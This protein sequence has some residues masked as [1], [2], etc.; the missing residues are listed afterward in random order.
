MHIL[1]DKGLMT[2]RG[3]AISGSK[4]AR[5]LKV[6][7]NPVREDYIGD[8][9][10]ENLA[11]NSEVKITDVNG[12]IVYQTR[13]NGGMAIWNGRDENNEK[14]ATGVYLIFAAN[15]NKKGKALGKILII[16]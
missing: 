4:E 11:Y 15:N 6:F 2:F 8:I 12:N 9:A 7:P 10:I 16:R 14:V 5:T 3:D 13:S 1:T